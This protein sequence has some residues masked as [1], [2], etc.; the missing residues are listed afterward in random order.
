[1]NRKHFLR[2]LPLL[3]APIV[4]PSCSGGLGTFGRALQSNYLIDSTQLLARL[5]PFFPFNRDY[6]GIG[7]LSLTN[8]A[9]ET[10][11]DENK[12][13]LGLGVTGGLSNQLS[14]QTG[15]SFLSNLAGRA[16]SGNCT[17]ACG[18]RYNKEDR[19]IYLDDPEL[20][21]LNLDGLASNYTDSARSLANLVGPQIL[22]KHP[23]HTL[24]PS[25]ATRALSNIK[26]DK[27]GLLLDFL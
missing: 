10:L 8:P 27:N 1:M 25:L 11:P 2:T 9:L 16:T 24:E 17:L 14:Q 15:L 12:I 13:L 6:S 7:Q 22:D 5:I 26:V 18:V 4:L 23:V 19:G 20:R 3:A 21:T